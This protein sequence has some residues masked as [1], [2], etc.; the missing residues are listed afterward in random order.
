MLATMKLFRRTSLVILL[1][2]ASGV[3]LFLVSL[4]HMLRE[5]DNYSRIEDHLY[6]GGAVA[7]PPRGTRAVV[8]LCEKEDPYRC[9]FH[10]WEP[11]ADSEP[12]PSLDWLRRMVDFLDEKQRAGVTTYVHC[13]N[14]VSRSGMLVVAYEMSKNHWTHEEALT[15]VR[16]KRPITRPNPAF[17]RLLLEWERIVACAARTK[18]ATQVCP[19]ASCLLMPPHRHSAT[20]GEEIACQVVSGRDSGHVL[21]GVDSANSSKV[22]D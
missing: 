13:R 22:A 3:S 4:A 9:E 18:N 8:N 16:S 11:I 12:A 20:P 15:F 5:A 19:T 6:L 17:L 1:T 21:A 10:V 2:A 14:G 7:A